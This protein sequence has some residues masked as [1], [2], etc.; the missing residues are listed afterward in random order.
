MMREIEI[1][2]WFAVGAII[3]IIAFSIIF[4][5]FPYQSMPSKSLS[6]PMV[7]FDWEDK[8]EIIVPRVMSLIFPKEVTLTIPKGKKLIFEGDIW[9]EEDFLKNFQKEGINAKYKL[10]SKQENDG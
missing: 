3:L 1:G 8:D 4:I 7:V 6:L 9:R 10:R 5:K 2:F